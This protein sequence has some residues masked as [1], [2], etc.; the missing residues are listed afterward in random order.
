[1]ASTL[2][3][4]RLDN[5]LRGLQKSINTFKAQGHT[6]VYFTAKFFCEGRCQNGIERGEL[7]TINKQI[8]HY[9][10]S[11]ESES[12]RVEFFS[13]VTGKLIYSKVLTDLRKHEGNTASKNSASDVPIISTNN[14]EL[15]AGFLKEVDRRLEVTRLNDEL[16]KRDN[17]VA[18]LRSK[19]SEL[20][21]RNKELE[22]SLKTKSGLEFYSGMVGNALPGLATILK[23]TRLE[24]AADFLFSATTGKSNVTPTGKPMNDE[25]GNMAAMASELYRTLN[26]QEASAIHLLL[27]AFASD[28]SKI[29]K[30]LRCIGAET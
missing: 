15:D 2:N 23:G 11:E 25:T 20:V 3:K 6:A 29:Q 9:V 5:L 30:A 28:H 24:N 27:V 26:A 22:A 18:E 14:G 10:V 21:N 17:E 19:H 4:Y 12:V 8:R 1:M 7:R 16:Q 13:E